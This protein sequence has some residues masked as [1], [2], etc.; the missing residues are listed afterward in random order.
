MPF[1]SPPPPKNTHIHHRTHQQG[2]KTYKG[3]SWEDKCDKLV[4]DGLPKSILDSYRKQHTPIF[5][6]IKQ[7]VDLEKVRTM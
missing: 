1:S 5:K 2:E 3:L 6:A 4:K 7:S